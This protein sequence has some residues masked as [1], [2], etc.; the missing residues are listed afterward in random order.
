MNDNHESVIYLFSGESLLACI[1]IIVH[2]DELI[3]N[4]SYLNILRDSCYRS[5]SR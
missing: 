4:N 1:F 3:L 2:S 5:S